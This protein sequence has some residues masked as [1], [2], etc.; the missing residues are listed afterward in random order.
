[1]PQLNTVPASGPPTAGR[2]GSSEDDL[3]LRLHHAQNLGTERG[4]NST[5][6]GRGPAESKVWTV[7][8]GRSTGP[9]AS[10]GNSFGEALKK[11]QPPVSS[12]FRDLRLALERKLAERQRR[13]IEAESRDFL[14]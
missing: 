7:P 2:R 12:G 11:A 9:L 1:M 3:P 6:A 4:L 10:P 14:Q 13:M 5:P 8:G